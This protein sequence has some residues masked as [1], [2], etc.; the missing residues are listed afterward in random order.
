M[1]GDESFT[2]SNGW[3]NR[4]KMRHGIRQLTITGE[5]LSSDNA[6]AQ[7]YLDEFSNIISEGGYSPQQVYNADETGLNFK[8]L[9]NKTLASQQENRAP[10]FKMEERVTLMACS[11][12]NGNHIITINDDWQS[13]KPE[14]I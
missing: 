13:K 6:A 8:A 9:P 5:Q 11:N 3:L 14:G 7:A 10:G 12:A 4:W 1:N 2:A